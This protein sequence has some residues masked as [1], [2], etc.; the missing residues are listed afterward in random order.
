[1]ELDAAKE[2]INMKPQS[3]TALVTVAILGAATLG[4]LNTPAAHARGARDTGSPVHTWNQQDNR[5]FS[6]QQNDPQ[7]RGDHQFRGDP[8]DGQFRDGRNDHN[9]GQERHAAQ[10]QGF[11]HV[12]TYNSGGYDNGAYTSNGYDNRS[13]RQGYNNRDY[14]NRSTNTG[15]VLGTGILGA[16]LGAVLAR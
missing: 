6:Y 7:L 10:S 1:M 3:R 11:H 16:V 4:V 14:N 9:W 13:D 2:A 8:A 12:N 15:K 5:Q